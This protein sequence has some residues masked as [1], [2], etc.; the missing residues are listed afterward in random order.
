MDRS[1]YVATHDAMPPTHSAASVSG[2]ASSS[3]THDA[4]A[5]SQSSSSSPDLDD[6]SDVDGISAGLSPPFFPFLRL[7]VLDFTASSCPASPSSRDA[8]RYTSPPSRD[9][10]DAYESVAYL[11]TPTMTPSRFLSDHVLWCSFRSRAASTSIGGSAVGTESA[12]SSSWIEAAGSS[13]VAARRVPSRHRLLPRPNPPG[14]RRPRVDAAS[15][16]RR[17]DRSMSPREPRPTRGGAPGRPAATVAC[18]AVSPRGNA[19]VF[20]ILHTLGTSC[21]A[22][23]RA[24]A[25]TLAR[26]CVRDF[27]THLMSLRYIVAGT[28][29]VRAPSDTRP[30]RPPT[31]SALPPATC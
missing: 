2:S 25:H 18:I 9:F 31:T 11:D 1:E 30:P 24:I 16:A 19:T 6:D 10:T 28:A 22:L 15:R 17:P 7:S 14:L 8:Q 4:S 23:H 3:L 12:S 21:K 13:S 20:D 5:V 26:L 27:L 29:V